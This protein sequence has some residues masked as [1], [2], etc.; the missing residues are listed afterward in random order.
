MKR[1]IVWLA[2]FSA[3]SLLWLC[4]VIAFG[5]SVVEEYENGFTGW[6]VFCLVVAVAC[7][8]A[9]IEVSQGSNEVK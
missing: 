9:S 5:L 7:W 4:S 8:R 1:A 3:A 6:H 2:R